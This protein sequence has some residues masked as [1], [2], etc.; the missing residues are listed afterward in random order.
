[1]NDREKWRKAYGWKE[2]SMRRKEKSG[3]CY[4]GGRRGYNVI[5]NVCECVCIQTGAHPRP[6]AVVCVSKTLRSRLII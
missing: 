2:S 4:H 3:E 6:P 1:M 5:I